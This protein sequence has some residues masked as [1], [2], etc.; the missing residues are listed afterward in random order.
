MN[1]N[2]L[3]ISRTQYS[4][5]SPRCGFNL[6]LFFYFS[7]CLCL[8]LIYFL[9]ILPP[10]RPSY[11]NLFL[12]YLQFLLLCLLPFPLSSMPSFSVSD[13]TSRITSG[14]RVPAA[15]RWWPSS[16]WCVLPWAPQLWWPC[17]SSW[18]S[19]ALPR[20]ST[21]SRQKTR[22][23]A[24][25]GEGHINIEIWRFQNK[26]LLSGNNTYE[27]QQII[28]VLCRMPFYVVIK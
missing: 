4:Q 23:C 2:W 15:S 6:I 11:L 3:W 9:V 19:C 20:S 8:L 27:A 18:S 1:Y 10:F 21:C 7:L 22:S 16:R 5:G 28:S 12:C 13:V 25:A 14:T 24:S 26:L 17:C